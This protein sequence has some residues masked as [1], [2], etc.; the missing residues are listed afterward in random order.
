MKPGGRIALSAWLRQG[1][2]A[3]RARLRA[4]LVAGMH[5][6]APGS[7]LFAWHDPEALR[8]LLAPYGFSVAVRRRQRGPER[9]PHHLPLR[10]RN[11]GGVTTCAGAGLSNQVSS[12][13]WRRQ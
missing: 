6:E 4:E 2:L 5:D 3:D 1:A 10:G 13:H 7:M 8:G 9:L 12:Y 11:R